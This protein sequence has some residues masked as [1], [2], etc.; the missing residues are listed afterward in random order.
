MGEVR[1]PRRV[2]VWFVLLLACAVLSLSGWLVFRWVTSPRELPVSS[3][4]HFGDGFWWSEGRYSAI[5]GWPSKP[6]ELNRPVFVV[7]VRYPPGTVSTSFSHH[8]AHADRDWEVEVTGSVE[9]ADGR[10]FAARYSASAKDP[11]ERF[12]SDGREFS[13]AAG[14]LFLVDLTGAEPS[15]VQVPADL[16]GVVRNPAGGSDPTPIDPT[17]SVREALGK[18]RERHEEVRRFLDGSPLN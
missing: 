2:R 15:V 9:R 8:A 3:H 16:D 6:P 18:L 4:G 11:V 1:S 12:V 17:P 7:L 14:R 5:V 10:R 13:A